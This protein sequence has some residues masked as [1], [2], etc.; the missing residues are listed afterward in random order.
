[1]KSLLHLMQSIFWIK[2]KIV[3]SNIISLMSRVFANGSE[4]QGLIPGQVR[5]RKKKN[6]TWCHFALHSAL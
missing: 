2:I 5:L 1:M 4:D 3:S 6:G